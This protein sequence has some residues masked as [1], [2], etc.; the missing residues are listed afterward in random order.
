MFIGAFYLNFDGTWRSNYE[1]TPADH[2]TNLGGMREK[3]GRRRKD[4]GGWRGEGEGGRKREVFSDS[5]GGAEASHPLA[6]SQS[7][8]MLGTN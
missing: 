3:E 2:S 1:K 7:Q 6:S 8:C 4:R 5:S